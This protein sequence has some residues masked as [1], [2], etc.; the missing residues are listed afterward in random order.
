MKE[1]KLSA[2]NIE[3]IIEFINQK[4]DFNWDAKTS[5][6]MLNATDCFVFIGQ[7]PKDFDSETGEVYSYLGGLHFDILTSKDLSITEGLKQH[8]PINP[9]PQFA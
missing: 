8:F 6:L 9:K 7:I 2:A 5:P 3:V 1:Y 4:F